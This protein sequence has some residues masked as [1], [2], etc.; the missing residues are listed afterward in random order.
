VKYRKQTHRS[1]NIFLE[2]LVSVTVHLSK[3]NAV[4]CQR[5]HALSS[6]SLATP[7]PTMHQLGDCEV[8]DSCSDADMSS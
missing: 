7:T 1:M 8:G 4:S 5:S 2:Q 3:G 6:G